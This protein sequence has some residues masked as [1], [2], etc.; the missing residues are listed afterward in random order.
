MQNQTILII[1]EL[2][3]EKSCSEQLLQTAAASA[4]RLA[5][6][7]YDA[8]YHLA[9]SAVLVSPVLAGG[10]GCDSQ[11]KSAD[12]NLPLDQASHNGSYPV[13]PSWAGILLELPTHHADS[14]GLFR[15]LRQQITQRYQPAPCPPIVVIGDQ[16]TAQAA[17]QLLK[18]GAADYLVRSQLTADQLQLALQDA[19]HS[20][21][22][23]DW[24]G[25][26]APVRLSSNPAPAAHQN[27][28]GLS[29]AINTRNNVLGT[30]LHE[31]QRSLNRLIDNLPGFAYRCLNDET[32]SMLFMSEA[33]QAITGYP[34][35]HFLDNQVSW[36]Q[37][38]H[39]DDLEWV[40][41]N[42]AQHI[43]RREPIQLT[44][45][46]ITAD[47]QVRWIL[48]RATPVFSETGEIE[49]WE[50]FATDTTARI[51]AEAALQESEELNQRILDSSSDCIKV[52]TLDGKI[53][54]IN[55]GGLSALGIEQ[56]E[57]VLN[58]SW[59]ELWRNGDRERAETAIATAVAGQTGHFQGFCPT[60]TGE[61][62]WW[63]IALT[64]LR[65]ASG[66]VVKIV[67]IS[68]DVTEQKQ[69]EAALQDS[70]ER[71]RTLADNIS[72]FAW[73]TDVTGWIFW[74]NQRWFDY[75]GTTLAQMQ[76]WGWQQV[77]HADHVDRVV[78]HFR[79]SIQTGQPWE[80]V[81]PL[82]GKDGTYRWFL[83]RALPIRDETGNILR[84]FGT[85]TDITELRQTEEALK[86]TTKRLNIALKSAP[87]TLFNQDLDLRYTWIYNPT[88]NYSVDKLIGQRDEDL[89]SPETSTQ[90]IQLKQQVIDSG[91]GLRQEVKIKHNDQIAYY[92][93]TVD[94]IRN[95]QNEIVGV[96]S[97]AVDIS[98]LKKAEQALR[99]SEDRFRMAIES[100]Q[101]GTWDW[102]LIT[103]K[104]V[105]D[106][107]C[108]AMFGLPP[109]A[110]TSIEV[111]FSGLHP[112]DRECLEQIV[113]ASLNPSGDG[114]YNTEF[115]TIGVEDGIE[116]WIA[117]KG[118]VYFASDGTPQRFVG[119]VLDI[120]ERKNAEV[121][122]EQLLQ[123]EQIAREKA[124]RANRIKDEFLAILSHELRS[125]LNPILGWAKLL[126]QRKFNEAETLQALATIERN[127]KLQTQLVDDL[128]DVARILRGKLSLNQVPL[129]L[130]YVVTTAID[131]MRKMA[132][133]RSI[134][135]YTDI[136][137]VG[138][139]YGD[140]TR[141]QQIVW[142][143]LS[144][145]IKFTSS[146]GQI[147]IR[148]QQ[149]DNWAHITVQDTGKGIKPEF[150]GHIFESFRQEDASTTRQYGGL[151]LG[152]AIVQYL[153]KAHGGTIT[154]DSAGEGLGATF[155]VRLPLLNSESSTS[156][157]N[158]YCVL[159]ANPNFAGL[160]ILV[161]D[162]EADAR[163]L[164]QMLLTE[165]GAEVKAVASAADALTAIATF[166]PDILISDIGM[167]GIDGYELMQQIRALPAEQ[168]GHI[169]AIALTAYAR[170]TDSQQA[171]ASGYQHHIAKPL[172][173]DQL[174]RTIVQLTCAN[175]HPGG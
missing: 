13:Y 106:A 68:R 152:L 149:V 11:R 139:V 80:D 158:E 141:L 53:L 46:I 174:L 20:G 113:Q 40:N 25:A 96:T 119:T 78:N 172:D 31:S 147:D 67:A 10:Q 138:Q 22:Q 94:P 136:E 126:Q 14:L 120:T 55:A 63:D 127:A 101:I 52:L 36:A 135:L 16:D 75:T 77:H 59:I 93:L 170:E 50:G 39:P 99:R 42:A 150:L 32:W 105:W 87:I 137:Q 43:E 69:A 166:Q 17:V 97:A 64:P 45:R 33:V 84:W 133:S 4:Y 47:Q 157:P 73:M 79:Q 153:V 160:R 35:A 28:N 3:Q 107:R 74:Y 121:L 56:P 66:Q 131:T 54:Y 108:K 48:D 70:E 118:Q 57:Q 7:P 124:E 156:Q 155:T 145:A 175:A 26:I 142:N 116:R 146:G 162:D 117:A 85:N 24:T 65:D 151:G 134:A 9:P 173:L 83:S 41:A 128:L 15:Q 60:L 132:E 44:Y 1:K 163:E 95:D 161:S 76:G 92:D 144:N 167:P 71:F 123:R 21:V 81:F 98:D 86:Q 168:G 18:A 125:P 109:K 171:L 6:Q 8:H 104:L 12:I 38:I 110:K 2:S 164:V 34:T 82:R 19:L 72:Q 30:T 140:N 89:V 90:L 29:A 91:K 23:E 169:P 111:F 159:P 49:F 129:N 27:H 148:L 143:L 114:S 5:V 37:L 130:A 100:A 154:A 115:R 165:H 58:T 88:Q 61:P 51:Q 112:D 122:K 103:N 102:N 62:R